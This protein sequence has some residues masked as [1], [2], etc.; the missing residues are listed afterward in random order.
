MLRKPDLPARFGGE[1]AA[2]IHNCDQAGMEIVIENVK[3]SLQVGENTLVADLSVGTAFYP[4]NSTNLNELLRHADSEMYRAKQQNHTALLSSS[5]INVTEIPN[6]YI[7][8]IFTFRDQYFFIS[9]PFSFQITETPS[10]FRF[11]TPVY[12]KIFDFVL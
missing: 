6:I 2:L 10:R 1:F 5:E 11:F 4:E 3:R 12:S 9:C 7:S 8:S